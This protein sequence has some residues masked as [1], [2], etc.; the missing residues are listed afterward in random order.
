MTVLTQSI[1][2]PTDLQP[3]IAYFSMEIG[4][5][6]AIPTYS[7][8]LGILAGDTIRSAADLGL[9]LVAVTLLHRKGYFFQRLD[10]SGWQHEEPTEWAPDDY[11]VPLE[12]R[13]AVTIAG[14]SVSLR[15]WCYQ[16][17]GRFGHNVPVY[18][19]DADLPENDPADRGLSDSLYGGDDRYRLS[20]EIV[21]G[22]GGLRLLRALGHDRIRRFHMN[23]GH[24]ALLAVELLHENAR[25]HHRSD[26]TDE[27]IANV[28]TQCVFTT[29]TPVPAG[30]DIFPLALA[31]ELLGDIPALRCPTRLCQDET[32]NMTYLALN[33]S[34]FVNGVA[35]RHG[36]VSR[37]M[38]ST[39][40][41]ESITNGVH[42]DF[43][44]SPPFQK[45]FDN[46]IPGWRSDNFS[47]RYALN[48][49]KEEIR[50]AHREAKRRLLENVNRDT[51][52]GMDI[53]VLTLGYARRATSYKRP[54]LVFYDIE[55]LR[56]IARNCAG[57][58]LVYAGKA[59]PHD[60]EGK[61]L[62]QNIIQLAAK[63]KNDVRIAYLPNY[64][65]ES[66]RA[67]TAGVDV[68]LNTPLPPLEASGTSGMKAALNAV[69]SLSILD[70]WWIEGCI[71]NVTGWAIGQLK[72]I[73]EEPTGSL[74]DHARD[75]Q[76]D[77]RDLY[78]KLEETIAPLF[79]KDHDAFTNVMAHTIALNGSFFNTQRMMQQ[80]VL[81]AYFT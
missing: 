15:A 73:P 23:E 4:I 81:K 36:E 54:D 66:A 7:G 32:L 41:V 47:L 77:A 27:D 71:E 13:V 14:R 35:K 70:G 8:G 18:F 65:I 46:H 5:E 69:P 63:L 64:D 25:N 12:T 26:I 68:W 45:L 9:P 2:A 34:H 75:S 61:K 56:N 55:R 6:T 39:Y 59:H 79:Y 11:M 53:D 19:L 17:T 74:A 24:P 10:P 51:N 52:A 21:L 80:Y 37:H 20:Q 62:I 33:L 72:P 16:V 76:A 3:R 58:Q 48:I 38:F 67:I 30:H 49:P 22:I 44:T 43:W 78:Q 31:R 42:A 57:L 50:A 40:K 60:R 29:H 28:R 1:H